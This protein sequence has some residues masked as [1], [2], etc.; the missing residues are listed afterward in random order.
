MSFQGGDPSSIR[1]DPS[2]RVWREMDAED[3]AREHELERRERVLAEWGGGGLERVR[4]AKE[5][6]FAAEPVRRFPKLTMW[7]WAVLF[8]LAA[9]TLLWCAFLLLVA[10]AVMA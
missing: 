3:E 10:V 9:V 2:D 6:G 5:L 1:D 8:L 7:D 4:P